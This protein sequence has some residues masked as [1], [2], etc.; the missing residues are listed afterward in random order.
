MIPKL[1]SPRAASSCQD[2]RKGFISATFA[3]TP[4]SAMSSSGLRVGAKRSLSCVLREG[5]LGTLEALLPAR[6]AG[7]SQELTRSSVWP[8]VRQSIPSKN[9]KHILRPRE[10]NLGGDTARKKQ[11]Q[12][13]GGAELSRNT[14]IG[15]PRLRPAEGP[16]GRAPGRPCGWQVTDRCRQVQ[17]VG[18]VHYGMSTHWMAAATEPDT[19]T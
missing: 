16:G 14:C 8:R 4:V 6:S 17:N 13:R 19:V 1:L 11:P 2:P 10:T 3:A 5:E 9:N 7:Q 15:A 18:R 12:Q